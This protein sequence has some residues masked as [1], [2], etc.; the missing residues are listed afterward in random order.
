MTAH[1]P[2][3]SRFIERLQR[4]M[5]GLQARVA[6]R[7]QGAERMRAHQRVHHLGAGFIEM[8]GRY[9]IHPRRAGQPQ[10]NCYF[11]LLASAVVS[12][13]KHTYIDINLLTIG[14][15]KAFSVGD[16]RIPHVFTRPGRRAPRAPCENRAG[17]CSRRTSQRRFEWQAISRRA[18]RARSACR[19]QQTR[20]A[21]AR[22]RR[23]EASCVVQMDAVTEYT[24]LR[25]ADHLRS[26]VKKPRDDG[27]A[28]RVETIYD[29]GTPIEGDRDRLIVQRRPYFRAVGRNLGRLKKVAA[30]IISR[31]MCRNIKTLFN[32][33]PPGDRR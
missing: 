26:A 3:R 31:L 12:L 32:F 27:S 10:P 23:A 28:L 19:C 9:K 20:D 30:R 8:R 33:N 24:A 2:E 7:D 14:I 13:P 15:F 5:V 11:G 22:R 21:V 6:L 4:H 17:P 25:A 29:P 16:P 18:R 1:G